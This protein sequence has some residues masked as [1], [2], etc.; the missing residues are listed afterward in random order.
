MDET[1]VPQTPA[2]VAAI[3]VAVA[4]E[5]IPL[6]TFAPRFPGKFLKG[7]DYVGDVAAFL[8]AFEAETK[9]VLWA[10]DRLGCKGLQTLRAYRKRQVQAL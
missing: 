3:L 9:I 7:I 8:G 10:V 5:E 6:A 2:Q 1:D 4:A